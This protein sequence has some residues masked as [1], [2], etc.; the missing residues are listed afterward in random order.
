MHKEVACALE[1]K[2]QQDCLRTK[3]IPYDKNYNSKHIYI[4]ERGA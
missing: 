4:D 1:R 3:A 2:V